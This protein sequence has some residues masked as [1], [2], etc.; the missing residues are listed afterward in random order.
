MRSEVIS[1]RV[2]QEMYDDIVR[3]ARARTSTITREIERRLEWVENYDARPRALAA[4]PDGDACTSAVGGDGHT[5]APAAANQEVDHM[6][7]TSMEIECHDTG[8][9]K[10]TVWVKCQSVADID[11][12][13]AWLTMSRQTMVD[14]KEIR[15]G[16]PLPANVTKIKKDQP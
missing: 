13:I 1:V 8:D 10:V 6:N 16:K 2:R 15:A 7:V 14:W 5:T 12:V 9:T 3:E 11:D 4:G